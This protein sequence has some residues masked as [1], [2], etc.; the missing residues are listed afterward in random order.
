M[1]KKAHTR[2]HTHLFG[3]A[4]LCF[5]APSALNYTP[6]QRQRAAVSR[7]KVRRGE[8]LNR[9]VFTLADGQLGRWK[10]CDERGD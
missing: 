9:K 5:D 8:T 1:F 7:M 4:D 10:G 3:L 6:L 2:A